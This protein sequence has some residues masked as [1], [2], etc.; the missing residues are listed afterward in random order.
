MQ[1]SV[2]L[3]EII[4]WLVAA[5]SIALFIFERRKNNLTPFYMNLQGI[6]KSCHAKAVF[7]FQVATHLEQQ[8][9]PADKKD[10]MMWRGVI[11]DFEALKQ[12]VMGVMKAV[13]PNKDAPF[14]DREYTMIREP[15][16]IESSEK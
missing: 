14:N 9:N 1:V 10:I 16:Q 11:S 5:V 3:H 12:M 15:N 7:Y 6:L 2:A 8:E 4:S 13:E